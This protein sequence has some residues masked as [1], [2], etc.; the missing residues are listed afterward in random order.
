MMQLMSHRINHLRFISWPCGQSNEYLVPIRRIARRV[1][2]FYRCLGNISKVRYMTL[3]S[4][5]GRDLLPKFID[6]VGECRRSI[7]TQVG[8]HY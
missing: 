1:L 2:P 4:K 7:L 6:S 8:S 5:A 3:I